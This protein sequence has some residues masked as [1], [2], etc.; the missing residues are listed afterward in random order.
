MLTEDRRTPSR[1]PNTQ[2]DGLHMLT[3]QCLTRIGI[4]TR[5]GSHPGSS[6][7]SGKE[8]LGKH[9]AGRRQV[10]RGRCE[11]RSQARPLGLGTGSGSAVP[12]GISIRRQT[13]SKPSGAGPGSAAGL[14]RNTPGPADHLNSDQPATVQFRSSSVSQVRAAVTLERYQPRTRGLGET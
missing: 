4:S 2:P 6:R 5:Q 10:S 11:I 9:G 1:T 7:Q 13:W 8:G 3:L 14:A 12:A